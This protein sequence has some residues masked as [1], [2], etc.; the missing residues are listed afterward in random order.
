MVKGIVLTKIACYA[1]SDK[2]LSSIHLYLSAYKLGVKWHRTVMR[3]KIHHI[4]SPGITGIILRLPYEWTL[5]QKQF[6]RWH[7]RRILYINWFCVRAILCTQNCI[8]GSQIA[9]NGF[10]MVAL[11]IFT[12]SMLRLQTRIRFLYMLGSGFKILLKFSVRFFLLL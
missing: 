2:V 7:F 9:Y 6:L 1:T 12:S 5:M 11:W 10:F 4:C 3:H 8:F